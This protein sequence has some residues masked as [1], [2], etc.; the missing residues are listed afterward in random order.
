MPV[1]EL[2]VDELALYD[3]TR[4]K[5]RDRLAGRFPAGFDLEG[6]VISYAYWVCTVMRK[7]GRDWE[8]TLQEYVERAARDALLEAEAEEIETALVRRELA[9]CAGP[10][11]ARIHDNGCRGSILVAA[12]CLPNHAPIAFRAAPSMSA[13]RAHDGRTATASSCRETLKRWQAHDQ[14]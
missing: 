1:G 12:R 14:P 13:P 10:A 6:A 9:R 7:P 11:N 2:S 8:S 5:L 3:A 4:A